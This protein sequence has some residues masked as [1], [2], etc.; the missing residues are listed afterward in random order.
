MWTDRWRVKNERTRLLADLGCQDVSLGLYCILSIYGLPAHKLYLPTKEYLME[1]DVLSL[2]QALVAVR[3]ETTESNAAVTDFIHEWLESRGFTI[4][5]L[6]YPD[7]NGVEKHNLVAKK[8]SGRG[9]LGFFSHSDTVPGDPREW[10]PWN[11]EIKGEKLYGRGSCDMK[12]PLAAS[13]IAAAAA[14]V[15]QLGKPIYLAVAAD[16]EQGHVGAHYIQEHAATFREN[17][18]TW[19]VI[20]EPTDLQPVYAHKGGARVVV[21]ATGRAAH[22]STD[23]GISANFLIAPF[24]AEVA[25]LATLFKN[26]TRF[27]NSEFSPPTNGFNLTIDDGQCR[28]NVTAA[29]TVAQMSIRVMPNDHHEEQIALVEAAARKHNLDVTSSVMQPF[30]VDKDAEIVQ[31]AC[32]ATGIEKAITVPYGTEAESYQRYTQCV[33]LGPGSIEQAHTIGEWVEIKQLENA[34][35][36]YT[37]MIE[38]LCK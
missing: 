24:L 21:T 22:T 26:E 6:S 10:E 11:P 33:I 31:A 7:E 9:G 17:W 28:T 38:D 5:R 29:K 13:M 14:D 1:Y 19:A 25:E 37:R 2:T 32:R 20:P 36:I 18:P 16:E 3:S 4:E 15:E 8:G 12:G 35:K 27:H 30:Y 34:V 23:K